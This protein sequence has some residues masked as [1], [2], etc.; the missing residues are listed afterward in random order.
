MLMQHSFIHTTVEA[1]LYAVPM[2]RCPGCLARLRTSVWTKALREHYKPGEPAQEGEAKPDSPV[3][4][5]IQKYTSN[6]SHL[7]TC[8]CASCDQTTTLFTDNPDV[9]EE[10]RTV[11]LDAILC[12]FRCHHELQV[13]CS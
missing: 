2:I 10:T 12:E 8:R 7:L 1:A 4:T 11:V 6:A 5:M 3:E 9:E 13:R